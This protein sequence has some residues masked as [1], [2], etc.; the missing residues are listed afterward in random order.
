MFVPNG[1]NT[2]GSWNNVT[3]ILILLFIYIKY[4]A[5]Y[6]KTN[7]LP[8][9]GSISEECSQMRVVA[10]CLTLVEYHLTLQA[11]YPLLS[12]RVKEAFSHFT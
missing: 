10:R 2:C 6:G 7:K 3:D 4:M 5:T 8:V 9:K 1:A 12:P 11:A